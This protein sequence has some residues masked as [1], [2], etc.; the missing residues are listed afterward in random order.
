MHATVLPYRLPLKLPWVAA[1]TTLTERLGALLHLIDADGHEGWGDCAP[2]PSGGDP[3]RVIDALA[4]WACRPAAA[5]FDALP[6]EARWAIETAQADLAAQRQAKPLWR[7]L[8]GSCNGIAVNAALGPLDAGLPDRYAQAAAQGF[9]IGKI[10]VGLASVEEEIARL[11]ALPRTLCLRLDANR[12]WDESEARRF[13]FAIR[14]LPIDAVEEPLAQPSLETLAALQAALPYALALD[15]S[16]PGFSLA[17]L[18]ESRAVRRLVVKPARL[19]GIRATRRIAQA[20]RD[21]G[22]ELVL[23]TVIDSA[24]GVAATAHLAAALSPD[25]AHGLGTS[26]WLADDLAAPPAIVGGVL[27]LPETA[28]LGFTPAAARGG[29]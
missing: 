26:A 25:L 20:A 19:G 4:A 12:S 3:Q 5:E 27:Q 18:T 10:K 21:A 17:A 2:L 8:G 24:I 1:R 16:L 7:H 13:L 22:I 23:T 15:E 14:A 9:R 28:G 6:C 11:F 29:G